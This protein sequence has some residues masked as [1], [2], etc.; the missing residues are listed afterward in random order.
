MQFVVAV[1]LTSFY[2]AFSLALGGAHPK[3]GVPW[4][5]FVPGAVA[6]CGSYGATRASALLPVPWINERGYGPPPRRVHLSWRAAVRLPPFA[7]LLLIPWHLLSILRIHFD[8]DWVVYVL[9]M[10]G[11][12]G[13][14]RMTLRRWGE[15]LSL[16]HI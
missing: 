13:L 14:A 4:W 11:V 12:G 15:Y 9:V 3:I 16:I 2:L 5:F 6:W 1:A 7:P 8:L 10:V